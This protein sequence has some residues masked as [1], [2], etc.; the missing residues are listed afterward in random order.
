VVAPVPWFGIESAGSDDKKPNE[1][2]LL[3]ALGEL[4]YTST[5][6]LPAGYA[7]KYSENVDLTEDF[8]DY[9][10][11]YSIETGVLIA[12]RKLVIKK[13]EVPLESWD[14]YKKFCKA[15]ADE[16]DRYIN[17][18]T[19]ATEYPEGEGPEKSSATGATFYSYETPSALVR[20]AK[21]ANPEADVAPSSGRTG[22]EQLMKEAWQANPEAGRLMVEAAQAFQQRD[23]TRA[24]ETV[25]RILVLDPKFFGAHAS[26][27]SIALTRNQPDAAVAEMRTEIEYHPENSAAYEFLS[28]IQ[29]RMGRNDDAIAT[30]RKWIAIDPGNNE[31]ALQLSRM[32]IANKNY[33][34]AIQVL[35]GAMKSSP[36]S[37]NLQYELARAYLYNHQNEQGL[38]LLKQSAPSKAGALN[39][40]AFLLADLNI[41][42]GLAKQYSDTAM[43]AL[44]ASCL[45]AEID[46]EGFT[47]TAG[48]PYVWDTV[49]WVYFR[50]GK[51]NDALPYLRSAWTLSQSPTEGYHLGQLYEKLGKTQEAIHTYK[52]ALASPGRDHENIRKRY[53][54]LTNTKGDSDVPT[55]RRGPAGALPSPGEELS[56]MRTFKLPPSAHGSGSAI[57]TVVFSPGRVDSVRYRSGDESLKSLTDQIAALKFKT[58]FPDSTPSRVFRRGM[59]VCSKISGCDFVLLL[60]DSVHSVDSPATS[61]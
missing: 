48:L 17:L 30:L 38:V 32:L 12:N 45:K 47:A 61:N 28:G 46:D 50:D 31:A 13:R 7:P 1:P 51:Y 60:P 29:M 56:R 3:G 44:T 37:T 6:I 2:I 53:E 19:S 5:T 23:Y 10:A 16:R 20:H 9:H 35:E 14:T 57:Y 49:G 22:N 33:A 43:A 34:E 55:L 58:E 39:D 26:L 59:L 11:V 8:A 36:D 54:G 24:E 21:P 15:L 4:V 27:A 52:L 42:L 40:A 41:D 25:Q 18:E